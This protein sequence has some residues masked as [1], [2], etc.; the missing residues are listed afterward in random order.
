[1]ESGG[2]CI[3]TIPNAL[4]IPY[5]INKYIKRALGRFPYDRYGYERNYS[6]FTFREICS[7]HLKVSYQSIHK[8]DWRAD[9]FGRIYP[10]LAYNIAVIIERNDRG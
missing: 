10:L 3:L 6:H 5:L 4:N 8:G 2:K 9:L 1:M 7:S